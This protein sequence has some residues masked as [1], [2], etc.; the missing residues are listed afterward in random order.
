RRGGR[1]RGRHADRFGGTGRRRRLDDALF[2]V[3]ARRRRLGARHG[4]GRLE[5]VLG[6]G[7]RR[8]HTLDVPFSSMRV[9][10]AGPSA[11]P[12]TNPLAAVAPFLRSS[13][14]R[15][16]T[17]RIFPERVLGSSATN[18]TARGYLYGAVTRLQ[19]SCSSFT[20]AS[21]GSKPGRRTTNALTMLPRSASG[22]PTTA[23]SIT[24]GCSSSA[25]STSNGPMRDEPD[26]ITSS[27]R[28]TNQK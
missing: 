28:P 20:S 11:K 8:L 9:A 18:S 22:E 24:A 4:D 3:R 12:Q 10:R 5:V 1:H 2:H 21:L 14:W 15:S 17:P 19:C 16:S 26:E 23:D 27:A 7:R 6:R 25:L 13:A